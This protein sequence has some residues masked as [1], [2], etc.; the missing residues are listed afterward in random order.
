MLSGM[1]RTSLCAIALIAATVGMAVAETAAE[2]FER[3]SAKAKEVK[4][5]QLKMTTTVDSEQMNMNASG[6]TVYVREGEKLMMRA[7]MSSTMKMGE[8]EMKTESL[9]VSD[10]TTMWS[11]SEQFGQV[12]VTKM[13]APTDKDQEK[14]IRDMINAGESKVLPEEVVDGNSC[15]VIEVTSPSPM[16]P[17]EK[18]TTTLYFTKEHGM[19][20]KMITK[21]TGMTNTISMTDLKF[22]IPVDKST[23]S[24]TPP[25]GATIN[26]M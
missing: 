19:M 9:M 23:F 20:V 6:V 13:A 17:T 18:A 3:A 2:V 4:S 12:S 1:L 22:N 26:E 10:G 14:V 25:E 24:Y 5:C 7:T 8:M 21:A 16:D 11:Q 15:D